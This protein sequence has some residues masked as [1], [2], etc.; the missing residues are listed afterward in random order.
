MIAYLKPLLKLK[1]FGFFNG[2][3]PSNAIAYMII[4]DN[5]DNDKSNDGNDGEHKMITRLMMP[6]N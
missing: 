4:D 1:I 2:P 6:M 5:A 3:D